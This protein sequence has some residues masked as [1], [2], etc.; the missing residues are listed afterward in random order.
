MTD[1]PSLGTPVVPEDSALRKPPKELSG[2]QV[3][4]LDGIRYAVEMADVA[5]GWLYERLARMA[6]SSSEPTTRDI[7]AVMLDA[8][9]VIDAVHRF[10]DLVGAMPGLPQGPWFRGLR[11]D[12]PSHWSSE[13][14]SNIRTIAPRNSPRRVGRSGVMSPGP[15]STMEATT[16]VGG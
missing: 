5:Y 11:S 3:L 2:R 9:S 15:R 1:G 14:A 4:I 16:P 13:T 8:W 12:A 7:A 10:V 6:R